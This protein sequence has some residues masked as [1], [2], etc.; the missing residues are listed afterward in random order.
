L[1]VINRHPERAL[2]ADLTLLGGRAVG[3]ALICEIN[4]E[5]TGTRNSFEK[6]DAVGVKRRSLAADIALQSYQFP[7]HS[8][9]VMKLEYE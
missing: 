7:A 2:P 3:Q 6:P 4:G 1:Y 5:T 9:T 8:V